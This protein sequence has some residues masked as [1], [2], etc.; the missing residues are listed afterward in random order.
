MSNNMNRRL[1]LRKKLLASMIGAGVVSMA[2]LPAIGWAQTANATL[3]GKAP[4][5]A[6]VTA[7]NVA[8][9]SVRVTTAGS[10]GA[11]AL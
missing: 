5:N 2:A 1:R 4:P 3:Q 11:Y 6:Q 10:D 7:R 8:T 9:G